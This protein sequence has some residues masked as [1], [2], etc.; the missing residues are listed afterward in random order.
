MRTNGEGS[1]QSS[2]TFTT[3]EAIRRSRSREGVTIS[4]RATRGPRGPQ[5]WRWRRG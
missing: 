2:P 1:F 3:L 5:S 4:R